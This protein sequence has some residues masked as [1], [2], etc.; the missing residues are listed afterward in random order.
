M[1]EPDSE[2][3]ARWTPRLCLWQL[4]RGR[5]FPRFLAGATITIELFQNASLPIFAPKLISQKLSYYVALCLC[6]HDPTRSRS[7]HILDTGSKMGRVRRYKK[8]KACDPCARGRGS[9]QCE[10][11]AKYDMA[12]SGLDSD[13]ERCTYGKGTETRQQERG[14]RYSKPIKIDELLDIV[15]DIRCMAPFFL[16]TFYASVSL[17]TCYQCQPSIMESWPFLR[18]IVQRACHITAIRCLSRHYLILPIIRINLCT[19][20]IPFHHTHPPSPPQY[21]YTVGG[22]GGGQK[23]R[24]QERRWAKDALR[25]NE[26]IEELESQALKK[27]K[28]QLPQASIQP[29]QPNEVCW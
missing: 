6:M 4:G 1:T 3:E 13:E 28:K 18:H 5:S 24:R 10:E 23:R 7:R 2:T 12:P 20:Q 26:Y 15:S 8:L 14:G 22:T 29:K 16:Y 19:P 21:K 25:D 27:R 9:A 11:D 17:F